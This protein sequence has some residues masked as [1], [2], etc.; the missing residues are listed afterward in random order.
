MDLI[1]TKVT[2]LPT[3]LGRVKPQ[4]YL[5]K[6]VATFLI[7]LNVETR[8]TRKS[9]MRFPGTSIQSG[10]FYEENV[11]LDNITSLG[12]FHAS[13]DLKEFREVSNNR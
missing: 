4:H 3:Q 10:Y 5:D 13:L 8:F 12:K 2:C 9:L 1:G 7:Q 11:S 6:N